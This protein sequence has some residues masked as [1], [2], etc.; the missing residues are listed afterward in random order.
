MSDRGTP[1]GTARGDDAARFVASR[2]NSI[3]TEAAYAVGRARPIGAVTG[4]STL[5]RVAIKLFVLVAAGYAITVLLGP[6]HLIWVGLV[7][8]W[9]VLRSISRIP[10]RRPVSPLM[11][12]SPGASSRASRG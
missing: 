5:Y 12:Q 11:R 7:G 8:I 9:L 4:H 1:D 6:I 10:R 2:E 3:G